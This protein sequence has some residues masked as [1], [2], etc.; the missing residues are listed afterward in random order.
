MKQ[1]Q[2]YTIEVLQSLGFTS[3][4][5]RAFI[6][7]AKKLGFLDDDGTPTALYD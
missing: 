5:N 6:S 1:P 7:F 3:I 4:N 2:K